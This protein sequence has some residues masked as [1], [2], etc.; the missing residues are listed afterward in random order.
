VQTCASTLE[1]TVCNSQRENGPR[2]H[3]RRSPSGKPRLNVPSGTGT[4]FCV[5][6]A[7]KL[8]LQLDASAYR[9]EKDVLAT[10]DIA[11]ARVTF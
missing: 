2:A 11:Q 7:A 9:Q 5:R 10:Y 8:N 3:S 4:G 6:A 1:S